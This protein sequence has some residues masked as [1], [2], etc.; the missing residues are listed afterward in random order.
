MRS[1]GWS[2]GSAF[3]F[4]ESFS[5]KHGR[6]SR[7]LPV[8]AQPGSIFITPPVPALSCPHARPDHQRQCSPVRSRASRSVRVPH[9][10]PAR[11]AITAMLAWHCHGPACLLPAVCPRPLPAPLGSWCRLPGSGLPQYGCRILE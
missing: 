11:R 7:R 10:C 9:A 1:D 8:P 5:F 4:T 3:M 6:R 2:C